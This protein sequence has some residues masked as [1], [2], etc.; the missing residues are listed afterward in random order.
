MG[1][2]ELVAVL[3]SSPSAVPCFAELEAKA[4]V[5]FLAFTTL[6]ESLWW[7]LAFLC[8]SQ[9][10]SRWDFTLVSGQDRR[11]SRRALAGGMN[12]LQGNGQ[13]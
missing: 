9:V 6:W 7:V 8:G 10:S 5:E 13:V 2:T 11:K 12:S 3:P 1:V 4:V